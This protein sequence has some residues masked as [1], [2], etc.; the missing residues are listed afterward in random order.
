MI[1]ERIKTLR[2]REK[3]TQYQL[4]KLLGVT[5]SAIGM[6]E[7]NRRVPKYEALEKMSNLFSVSCGYLLGTENDL[8]LALNS[9]YKAQTGDFAAIMNDLKNELVEQK[10][11][12]FKGEILDEGDLEK[13]F[14]AMKI[15]AEVAIN[16]KKE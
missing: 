13:I 8:D 5:P 14:E 11:L 12:M 7:Q 16:S 1:G 9:G 3:M 2:K 4:A 10:G 15:G 6:Y